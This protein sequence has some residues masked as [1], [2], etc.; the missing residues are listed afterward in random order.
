MYCSCL[1]P[2][3]VLCQ[4]CAARTLDL[5]KSDIV[6]PLALV[7]A[8]AADSPQVLTATSTLAAGV[9]LPARRVILR[10]LW[11]GVGEVSRAQ[12]LQMV[13][14]A[15]RAGEQRHGANDIIHRLPLN[16]SVHAIT[17]A[18]CIIFLQ[19]TLEANDKSLDVNHQAAQH[20]QAGLLC[21]LCRPVSCGGVFSA[22]QGSC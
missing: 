14:R 9:N 8:S 13:G 5:L 17:I 11:Q 16:Q 3:A 12:Y 6:D 4:L 20:C 19:L 1:C 7:H 21:T 2:A 10:S 22:G 15:G 18:V